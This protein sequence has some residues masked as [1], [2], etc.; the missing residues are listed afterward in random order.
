MSSKLNALS[1]ASLAVDN[2]GDLL[3]L[4]CVLKLVEAGHPVIS[5]LIDKGVHSN[6]LECIGPGNIDNL[7]CI[8]EWQDN[9]KVLISWLPFVR[10]FNVHP[11]EVDIVGPVDTVLMPSDEGRGP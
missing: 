5:C 2:E 1:R 4:T 11:C 6:L 7:S 9:Q 3:F 10:N 8:S